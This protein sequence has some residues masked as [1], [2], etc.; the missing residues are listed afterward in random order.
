MYTLRDKESHRICLS[1]ITIYSEPTEENKFPS[2]RSIWHVGFSFQILQL[3][4]CGQQFS[5]GKY[6]EGKYY[7]CAGLSGL[8]SNLSQSRLITAV[9]SLARSFTSHFTHKNGSIQD[10]E[11]FFSNLFYLLPY[12]IR[13]GHEKRLRAKR[14]RSDMK[15]DRKQE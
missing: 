11:V 5:S 9:L 10:L 13:V 14:Y 12:R 1:C 3:R 8:V 2:K 15:R 7:E 4:L 6:F